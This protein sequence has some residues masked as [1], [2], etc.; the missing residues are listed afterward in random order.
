MTVDV[1]AKILG[2]QT[3]VHERTL[4][5]FME[6]RQLTSRGDMSPAMVEMA[7][8]PQSAEIF[9]NPV[10]W[11]PCICV[12]KDQSTILM[13]PG[14]PR[15]MK[16]IFD[17]YVSSLIT[18]RYSAK[19]ATLRVYVT[20]FEAEVSPILQQVMNKYPNVYLK[21]YV[22][23]RRTDSQYMPVD[24]VSTGTDEGNAQLQLQRAAG[25]FRQLVTE[26]G[27]IFSLE[28]DS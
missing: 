11:A 20:M 21:A 14:P 5:S 18:E 16:G 15:E 24:L 10:G 8:V 3:I 28:S 2:K 1:V 25:H 27:K 13:M 9:Q 7:T 6:R 22:A 12:T 17:A 4:T 26:E 19:T 23:L